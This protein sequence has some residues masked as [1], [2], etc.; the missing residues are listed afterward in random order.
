MELLII[1][2]VSLLVT[3]FLVLTFNSNYKTK[4]KSDTMYSSDSKNSSPKA[5]DVFHTLEESN[6]QINFLGDSDGQ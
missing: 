5:G 4:A 3:I 1:I 6:I 2:L